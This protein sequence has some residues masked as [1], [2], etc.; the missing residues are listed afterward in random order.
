MQQAFLPARYPGSEAGS[1]PRLLL[2]REVVFQKA[3]GGEI[4]K[5]THLLKCASGEA[6]REVPLTGFRVMDLSP[7]G[8]K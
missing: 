6:A 4:G 1:E 8:S 5:G 3:P 2:G 7:E